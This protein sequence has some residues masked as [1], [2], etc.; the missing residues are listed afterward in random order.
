MKIDM[1]VLGRGWKGLKEELFKLMFQ[2]QEMF[3]SKIGVSL[4]SIFHSTL[5]NNGILQL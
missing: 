1:V 3:G 5:P 2:V 4:F